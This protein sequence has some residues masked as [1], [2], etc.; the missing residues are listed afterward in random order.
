MRLLLRE[1]RG[2]ES[3]VCVWLACL[4]LLGAAA[5]STT[6]DICSLGPRELVVFPV[7]GA[8]DVPVDTLVRVLVGSRAGGL[9]VALRQD[10]AAAQPEDATVEVVSTTFGDVLELRTR[11]E[12][13]PDTA[14][15][16]EVFD[17]SSIIAS[18]RFSTD[19]AV[20]GSSLLDDLSRLVVGPLARSEREC[21]TGSGCRAGTLVG[22]GDPPRDLEDDA[23]LLLLDV[24][25]VFDDRCGI[26]RALVDTIPHVFDGERTIE[27][28]TDR[29]LTGCFELELTDMRGR[30]APGDGVVCSP[31]FTFEPRAPD[32]SC[33][34]AGGCSCRTGPL[35]GGEWAPWGVLAGLWWVVRRR[36]RVHTGR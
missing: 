4:W 34:R 13:Q 3:L 10:E 18:S 6:P 22:I 8:R 15:V 32:P 27:A 14:Y 31:G 33:R 23:Q 11:L 30:V 20:S 1:L 7:D 35:A 24:F 9:R 19:A 26:G 12:L 28:E 36:K 29:S 17:S 2:L 5:C 25:E 16:A 21:C